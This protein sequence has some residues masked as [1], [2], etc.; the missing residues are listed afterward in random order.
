[1]AFLGKAWRF[2]VGVK[3]ALVLL[4][5]LVF[6]G[7]LYALL[8]GTP[9]ARQ[10]ED[11]ALLVTLDGSI[12][13][14]P[15]GASP[16][17][18][19]SGAARNA[20]QNRLRDVVY[21]IETAA[22]DDRVKVLA[23]DLDSFWGGGQVALQRVGNALD[24]FRKTG[25]PVIA[26]ATAYTDDSYLLAA[27]A[28]EV[29]LD[30]MGMT[31]IAGPGGTQPY[32]KGLID[33]L[34]VNVHVYRV[35]KF[36]SFVEPYTRTEQSPEAKA[37]GQGL[38]DALFSAW[39]ADVKA[40]R[41][42]AK[43]DGYI[44]DPATGAVGGSY[45]KAAL[46]AGMVDKLGD[47]IA[48]SR[49]VGEIAGKDRDS[50]ADTFRGTEFKDY[51]AAHPFTPHGGRIGIVTVAGAI[52]DGE[53]PAGTAGGDT[54]SRLILDALA[55]ADL[56]ALV[57]RVD[58]PGGSAIAAE[59]IRLAVMEAK[60]AKLPVTVSLGN[61]AA[62]GGYW[63]ATAG[64]KVFA[65]PSTITGSIGVFGILPTFENTAAKIGVSGD[66]IATTPLSGQPD[67]LRGTNAITDQ[68]M[69]G[70]VED[71]YRRF[72][73][74]VAAERN[75]PLARVE[76]IAQG[77]VWDG[78]S[79]RQLGLIDA[80]GSLDD[81]VAEAANRAKLD[82]AKVRPLYLDRIPSWMEMLAEGWFAEEP[83][84]T[85][86]RDAWSKVILRQQA[87]MATGLEDGLQ[88]LS[89]PAVQVRCLS[90]PTVPRMKA[91]ESFFKT[92]LNKVIS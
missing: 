43:L 48:W 76:E 2:L 36:K 60:T 64:D 27:H 87:A 92:L 40:A 79:A 45:S 57:V 22:S 1:M 26:F 59:R 5:L 90:C 77:R 47:R 14:Q 7:A 37:A 29:W 17:E 33:K 30:P 68:L 10:V 11:G 12:V 46:N 84:T 83:A 78:G 50:A 91:R 66:G 21:G 82:P 75:L 15:E 53:A 49:R 73:G 38:A 39:K 41:P 35:G 9:N 4:L 31:F 55:T 19:L 80:F 32:F 20:G 69:Q 8:S 51:L 24:K 88:V 28:S 67:V 18:L 44:A 71:I 86:A 16:A 72:T 42:K 34:G 63:I 81:A 3:D 58:S 52:V 6:F 54:I 13:E 70:G 74:L 25:K 61:V 62:S 85:V 23:L 56:D 89:G 65:E